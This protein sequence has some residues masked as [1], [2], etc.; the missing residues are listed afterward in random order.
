M[1]M[2]MIFANRREAGYLLGEKLVSPELQG[3]PLVLGP[4]RGG[5][6]VAFEIALALNAPLDVFIVRK[7]GGQEELEMGAI[8]TGGIRVLNLEVVNG[9]RIPGHVIDAVGDREEVELRRRERYYRDDRKKAARSGTP[10]WGGPHRAGANSS[11][12]V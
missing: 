9:F 3:E 2:N 8:A 12:A 4:P 6:P 7:L 11:R 5:A 1:V 10:S